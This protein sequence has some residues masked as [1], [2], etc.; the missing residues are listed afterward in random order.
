MAWLHAC[1]KGEEFS[2][3]KT[4][5]DENHD[6][7]MP[8]CLAHYILEYLFDI[9]L[10]LGDSALNH[11]EIKSWQQNTGV[12]LQPW[13]SRFLKRLSVIYLGEFKESSGSE[14]ETA[15]EEAPH[16]MRMSYRKMLKSRESIRKLA[17]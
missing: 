3:Q 16:Y 7:E 9:G 12:E 1:P 11:T 2:R 8:D 4:F 10:T 15:W 17:K 14:K 5:E 6:I 13:E